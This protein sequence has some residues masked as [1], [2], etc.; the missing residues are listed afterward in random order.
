VNV[1][2]PSHEFLSAR[3]ASCFVLAWWIQSVMVSLWF[4]EDM[5]NIHMARPC[6]RVGCSGDVPG[7]WLRFGQGSLWELAHADS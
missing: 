6:M 3:A 2:P 5:S 7:G 4:I 1:V